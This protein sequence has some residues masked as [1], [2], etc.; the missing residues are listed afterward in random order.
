M[1]DRKSEA[2]G[3]DDEEVDDGYQGEHWCNNE[4]R[5][6]ASAGLV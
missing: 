2:K 4:Q 3:Q 5:G 1:N 6:F